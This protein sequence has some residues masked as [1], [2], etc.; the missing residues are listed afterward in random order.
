MTLVMP[1]EVTIAGVGPV[2]GPVAERIVDAALRC[3]ARWGLA[4]TTLDDV[5][6]EAACGRATLY[7]LFPGGRDALFDAV[8][9]TEASRFLRCIRT[10]ALAADSLEDALVGIVVE[11]GRA[12]S[13]HPALQFLLV[14][15]PESLL[16]HLAFRRMD[17]VLR[18]VGELGG[19]LLAPWLAD[20][21]DAAARAAEWVARIVI[22]YLTSP[23]P[24]VDLC[25]D[26]SVRRLVRAFVLP[27]LVPAS[28]PPELPEGE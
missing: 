1:E 6:R 5:A 26:A 10:R 20:G 19:P 25:D 18:A 16:S 11:A 3:V 12:L 28:C 13:G 15:E 9:A 7:R 24:D 22:S 27:G 21:P 17:G 14:H 4:K 8:V 23:A 2:N